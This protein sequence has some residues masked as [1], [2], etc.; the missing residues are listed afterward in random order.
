MSAPIIYCVNVLYRNGEVIL[1]AVLSST[2]DRS[3]YHRSVTSKLN[4]VD[5]RDRLK[6]V[7]S[8]Y[9]SG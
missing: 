1:P 2:S 3:K 9:P 6:V 8:I 4:I 5:E 7:L